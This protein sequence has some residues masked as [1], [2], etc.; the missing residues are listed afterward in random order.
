[1]DESINS[2][3]KQTP[4]VRGLLM[5]LLLLIASTAGCVTGSLA[6]HTVTQSQ[7]AADYRY[8]ATL[9]ALAAVAANP[10][11]LP[12]YAL[13][14]NGT[15][16][17]T[18][19]GIANSATLWRGNPLQFIQDSLMF[20]GTHAPMVQWTVSPVADYTQLEAL[21]AACRWVLAGPEQMDADSLHIL[22]DPETDF[23]PGT[24]FGVVDRL[25]R[26]PR[27]WLH[28][29]GLRDI[30]TDACYREHCGDTWVSV[31]PDGLTGLAEFTLVMQDIS[32]LDVAPSDGTPPANQTPPVLVTLWL[33]EP[34]IKQPAPPG[35]L[36]KKLAGKVYSEGTIQ[37]DRVLVDGHFSI[38]DLTNPDAKDAKAID[39]SAY[40]SPTL[41]FRFD[42][43]IRPECKCEIE[44][45]LNAKLW[46]Q[47]DRLD[48]VCIS[49][50]EWMAWTT[51][52]QGFRSSVKPGSA[53]SKPLTPP[54]P[55]PTPPKS[56]LQSL[57]VVEL[58][59]GTG[60]EVHLPPGAPGALPQNEHP[61][62]LPDPNAP[63][64]ESMRD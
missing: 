54:G 8:Q 16:S 22:S 34:T 24:H 45:R 12:S 4:Q 55:H 6:R 44:Q 63:Y 49:W 46:D 57:Q 28:V 48:A 31:G 13:L 40:Y 17:V 15:T 26:L 14:S 36:P 21:R 23:T 38:T 60:E 33:V 11:T 47:S 53:L 20:T 29:G 3:V 56:V 64:C 30:S 27:G 18:N 2:R 19:I 39:Y 10:G 5:L 42:R 52:Y 51:P 9:K 62:K 37:N 25:S 59:E 41:V 50:E 43:V 35:G 58:P 7:S 1:M 32:T 61:M